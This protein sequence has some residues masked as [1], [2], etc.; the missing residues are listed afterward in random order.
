MSCEICGI[1]RNLDRHHIKFRGMGGSR[2]PEIHAESNLLTLCRDCHRKVHQGPWALEHSSEGIRVLDRNTGEQVM[3]RFYSTELDVPGLF[4]QL[5][6]VEEFLSRLS[7]SLPYLADDQLVE[8]FAYASSYGKRSWLIQAAVLYEAQQ[9]SI[10]GD[11][12][13]EAIA[14]RF[15]ISLRQAQKYALA[16]KTFFD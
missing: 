14:R 8:A 13:L 5:N 11:Q 2:D 10:Y 15:E 7:Q 4:Q 16:W 3:R 6:Q 1:T 12:A 9:R